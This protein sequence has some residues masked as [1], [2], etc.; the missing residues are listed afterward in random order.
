MY[1]IVVPAKG[2][3]GENAYAFFILPSIRYVISNAKLNALYS[4]I[5]E[6]NEGEEDEEGLFNADTEKDDDE[7]ENSDSPKEGEGAE[8][9]VPEEGGE[10]NASEENVSEGEEK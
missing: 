5:K 9:N 1:Q 7:K 4:A 3:F 10:I 8:E 6:I 2:S